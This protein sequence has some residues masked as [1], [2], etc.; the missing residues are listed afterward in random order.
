MLK[1]LGKD[2]GIVCSGYRFLKSP[3]TTKPNDDAM[4][5]TMT[6][7]ELKVCAE[8]LFAQA[9]GINADAAGVSAAG[10]WKFLPTGARKA[11]AVASSKAGYSAAM[12]KQ[13]DATI[14]SK[15]KKTA[16]IC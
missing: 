10:I 9:Y 12:M 16:A 14:I 4:T 8:P 2:I 5:N 6:Y 13:S 3:I 7:E 1:Q 11:M 15:Q